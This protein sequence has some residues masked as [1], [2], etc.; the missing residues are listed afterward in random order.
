MV[1]SFPLSEVAVPVRTRRR[2]LATLLAVTSV[3]GVGFVASPHAEA[4][5]RWAAFAGS[6]IH[7]G[8]QT[9][10]PIGQCT[11]NFVFYRPELNEVYVGQAAHCTGGGDATVTNGCESDSLPLGTPVTIQGASKPGVLV[12]SSWL[13][14]NA[15]DEQDPFACAYNDFALVKVDPADFAKVNPSL[16][17]WGGPRGI[18]NTGTAELEPVFTVGNS[19][20]RQ[21]IGL[22]MPKSG[23]SLGTSEQGWVH[24]VYTL[25]PGIPGDSGSAMVNSTGLATGIL[26]T[27]EITP[28]PAS[29]LFIDLAKA[30]KYAQSH[31][32]PGLRLGT[33]T[34]AFNP[35]QLPLG[36]GL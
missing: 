8:V 10:S 35:N 18:N 9:D 12:Y 32:M 24:Q 4:K 31:G 25:T 13:A 5:V 7:P 30:M 19:G 23:I 21:G 6:T 27:I 22:L 29:N 14:M 26:S 20:L 36:L 28:V 3:V 2:L 11:A 1:R 15:I 16:P 34:V 33:T 17:H